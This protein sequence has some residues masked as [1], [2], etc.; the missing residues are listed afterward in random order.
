M[1]CKSS[2]LTI[3]CCSAWSKKSSAPTKLSATQTNTTNSTSTKKLRWSTSRVT[4]RDWVSQTTSQEPTSSRYSRSETNSSTTSNA[5]RELSPKDSDSN[6]RR[7]SSMRLKLIPKKHQS[8]WIKSLAKERLIAS[9]LLKST[10]RW[11]RSTIWWSRV[12]SNLRLMAWKRIARHTRRLTPKSSRDTSST[13]SRLWMESLQAKWTTP[14][15]TRTQGDF[16]QR[17]WLQAHPR[18]AQF[19]NT[20]ALRSPAPIAHTTKRSLWLQLSLVNKL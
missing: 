5:S 19:T 12:N 16:Q 17:S 13:S 15:S 6:S 14:K 4:A 1:S 3:V 18:D 11:A 20:L 9:P 8:V 2:S 10:G 7:I